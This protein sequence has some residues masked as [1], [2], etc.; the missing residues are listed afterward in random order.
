MSQKG[1]LEYY[2][3]VLWVVIFGLSLV[4]IVVSP[5]MRVLGGPPLGPPLTAVGTVDKRANNKAFLAFYPLFF[6]AA[7]FFGSWFVGAPFAPEPLLHRYFVWF[8]AP[9]GLSA[10]PLHVS[11]VFRRH[12]RLRVANTYVL[13][14]CSAAQLPMLH[15]TGIWAFYSLQAARPGGTLAASA[16]RVRACVGL[17]LAACAVIIASIVWRVG[18]YAYAASRRAHLVPGNT[19]RKVFEDIYLGREFPARVGQKQPMH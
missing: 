3:V 7:G 4:F 10:I 8:L 18:A 14:A 17:I 11:I 13:V 16:L 2:P 19:V 12:M 15:A 9:F 6:I 5:V 1:L